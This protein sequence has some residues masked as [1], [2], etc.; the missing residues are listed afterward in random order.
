ML[1]QARILWKGAFGHR[2]Y[3]NTWASSNCSSFQKNEFF[4]NH[5][6]KTFRLFFRLEKFTLAFIHVNTF[7]VIIRFI[8]KTS[9]TVATVGANT[10]YTFGIWWAWATILVKLAFVNI[11][12]VSVVRWYETRWANLPINIYVLKISLNILGSFFTYTSIST[13]LVFASLLRST[14]SFSC[15]AFINVDTLGTISIQFKAGLTRHRI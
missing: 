12:A 13:R 1:T 2:I 4:D 14:D 5:F 8:F 6:F 11:F 15:C 3:D 9:L 10:I 7:S